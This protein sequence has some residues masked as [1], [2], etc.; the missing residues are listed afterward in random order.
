MKTPGANEPKPQKTPYYVWLILTAAVALTVVIRAGLVDLPLERDEGEYAYAARL[1]LEEGSPPFEKAYNMKMPGI[2]GAY[3]A[4]MAAFGPTVVGIR[5]GAIVLYA[6]CVYF[7]FLLF[8]R[9]FDD[10]HALLGAASYAFISLSPAIH[11][12]MANAEVFVLVFALPGLWLL[13]KALDEGRTGMLA[14]AGVLL[15]AGFM[16][17]QHGVFFIALGGLWFLYEWL[18]R[19]RRPLRGAGTGLIALVL[20]GIAPFLLTALVLEAAGVFDAFW[21]WTFDYAREYVGLTSW[22]TGLKFLLRRIRDILY[23]SGLFFLL[24]AVG[25][26]TV[27][28][29]APA[30]RARFFVLSLAVLSAA[31]V[32]PGLYFRPHYFLLAAPA[33]GLAAGLGAAAVGRLLTGRPKTAVASAVVLVALAVGWQLYAEKALYFTL[34]PD[35]AARRIYPEEPFPET[36]ALAR[37][38]AQRAEPG[39]QMAIIG[40]EPQVYFYARIKAAVGYMYT[41]PLTENHRYAPMMQAQFQSEVLEAE[42]RFVLFVNRS[43]MIGPDQQPYWFLAW[44]REYIAEHYRLI[45]LVDLHAEGDRVFWGRAA[46]QRQ[47]A[48]DGWLALYERTL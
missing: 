29:Y 33:G 7:A 19:R 3:A 43:W 34:S 15:G 21:L 12:V 11:G 44:A 14:G 40:S 8:R 39:D 5:V 2:Y 26:T 4:L 45:G 6:A 36:R 20:G 1:I 9:R 38:I 47:P 10:S 16:M 30:R 23:D 24:S 27:F 28:W 25:L 31:A 42:P 17:K 46:E 41:Y 35:Q 48:G 32:C 22:S 37:K 18:W 13:L